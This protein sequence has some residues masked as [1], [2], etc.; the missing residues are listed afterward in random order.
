[1]LDSLRIDAAAL[2]GQ[3]DSGADVAAMRAAY[4]SL[5]AATFSIAESLYGTD[6]PPE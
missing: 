6:N 4:Q 3:I 2:R 1:M 5:E